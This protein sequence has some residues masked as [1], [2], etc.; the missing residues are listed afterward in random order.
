MQMKCALVTDGRQTPDEWRRLLGVTVAGLPLLTRQLRC[1]RAAGFDQVTLV[2]PGWREIDV[3]V[4]PGLAVERGPDRVETLPATERWLLLQASLVLDVRLLRETV[5][6]K[7]N[8]E[9]ACVPG[10]LVTRLRPVPS[11][12]TRYR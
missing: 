2:G 3:T 4:V 9:M 12:F 11:S 1:L 7:L 6:T 8:L 5:F 10:A